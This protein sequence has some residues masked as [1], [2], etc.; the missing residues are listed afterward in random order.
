LERDPLRRPRR[1][2]EDNMKIDN[3]GLVMR[4]RVGW[5]W[6]RIVPSGRLWY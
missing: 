5:N 2:W 1:T 3:R 6:H 4:I